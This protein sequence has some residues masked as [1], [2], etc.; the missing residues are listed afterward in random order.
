MKNLDDL[1]KIPELLTTVEK[2]LE[3]SFSTQDEIYTHTLNFINKL[4]V[5]NKDPEKATLD[6]NSTS[7]NVISASCSPVKYVPPE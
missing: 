6:P 3:P 5:D 2:E 4:I 1:E 7:L